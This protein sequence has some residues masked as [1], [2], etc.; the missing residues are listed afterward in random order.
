MKTYSNNP[1]GGAI[2][3]LREPESDHRADAHGAFSLASTGQ[4]VAGATVEFEFRFTCGAHALEAGDTVGLA[5]RLPCDWG[6]LQTDEPAA[7]NHVTA[8]TPV[9]VQF[10]LQYQDRGG[11]KPWHHMFLA[12]VVAGRMVQG[13]DVLFTL[14]DRSGGSAGW[15]C[16]R[17]AVHDHRFLGLLRSASEDTWL[18]LPGLPGL[19]IVGGA[20]MHLACTAP[21]DCR[22]GEIVELIVRLVDRYGNPSRGGPV[23]IDLEAP[24]LQVLS[25]DRVQSGTQSIDV[26][27]A[28]VIFDIPGRWRP[29]IRSPSLGLETESNP[30]DCTDATGA[31]G[32]YWGDLHAGQCAMGC[33]QGTLHEFYWYARNVAGLQF[34]SHQPNDVYVTRTDWQHARTVTDEVDAEGDFVAFHGCEWTSLPSSGGDRNVFYLADQPEL[35]R[36]GRWYRED[37]PDDWPDAEDP[38]KLYACLD[39]T[40][41]LINLHAGGF[42]SELDWVN[43]RLERLV[44]IH[45]THGTSRWLVDAAL[46][47][48]RRF[49]ISAGTDGI[50]GRPGACLPGQRQTRNVPNGC[51]G[52][53]S[54]RLSREDVW[55][56]IES[57]HCYG[58]DGERIR[59][60]VMAGDAFMGEELTVSRIPPLEIEIG[61]TAAIERVIVRR[62]L[63]VIATEDLAVPDPAFPDRY[64]L[65]WTGTKTHGSFHAQALEWAGEV[66]T[67]R[68]ALELVSTIG[69][70]G[71]DDAVA[72]VEGA[73]TWRSV[74]AGNI[75]G[76]VFDAPSDGKERLVLRTS[77]F[78]MES[79]LPQPSVLWRSID[80]SAGTGHLALGRAPNP[81]ASRDCKLEIDVGE[82]GRAGTHAYWVEVVQVNG[83]RAWSSPIFVTCP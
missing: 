21:S 43:E 59:L 10:D 55:K 56:G 14:G 28:R 69:Y 34:A 12:T 51:F 16:Q 42:T 72:Q 75:V 32:L 18:E 65:T 31:V 15:E 38:T 83:S 19:E 80:S 11:V 60:A 49:G 62:G 24:G 48:G 52:V 58:T 35:H 22:V 63:S 7:P 64:R 1:D 33:G 9:G 6:A 77:F 61:G 5:W 67:S 54:P 41:A 40:E 45:S 66:R 27:K 39:G 81:N 76:F 8:Q 78:E 13:E 70:Y 29:K 26:W 30:I 71:D 57:R 73:I 82:F 47:Q 37:A 79:D 46:E 25:M 23:D 2:H 36:A 4:I 17:A 68:A 74:T 3:H 20:P 44:E 53:Y 50:A